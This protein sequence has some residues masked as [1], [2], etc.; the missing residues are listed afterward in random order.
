MAV[1]AVAVVAA[2]PF[3]LLPGVASAAPLPATYTATA[4]GDV[5]TVESTLAGGELAAVDL[6]HSDA[7]VDS[8]AD[9]AA[10]A[11]SANLGAQVG[12]F[13]T[14]D[15]DSN[16]TT[17]PPSGSD[18]GSLLEASA[19]GLNTGVITY[20]DTATW[21]GAEACVDDGTPISQAS[22]ETAGASL[23]LL[24]TSVLTTGVSS[25]TGTTS[26]EQTDPTFDTRAVVATTTGELTDPAL[27]D[28]LLTIDVLSAPTLTATATGTADGSDVV[29]TPAEAT[30]TVGGTT[31]T[32]DAGADV[33][34]D[35]PGVGSV[36]LHL[37]SA[38]ELANRSVAADGT[39][40]SGDAV[41]LTAD[42]TL[43]GGTGT[44]SVDLLPLHAEATAP[45]G[46]VE[47]GRLAPA[48]DIVTP[49]DGSSTDDPTPPI[50]GTSNQPNSTVT[51]VIDGGDPVEVDTDGD[52]NFTY[53]P[54]ASVTDGAGDTATDS[55]TFTVVAADV[56]PTVDITSPEDGSSTDDPTPPI[57]GTSN[58][59]NS[60]VTLVIDGGDPVEVDTDGDGNFT[61]TPTAENDAG[62]ASDSVT[63]TVV[64]ADEEPTVEI[65]DPED[66]SSTDD[67]TPPV[68]GTSNQPNSTVTV[69]IDGGDPVE[70]DT[71]GDGNF[72]YTPTTALACGE[73]TVTVTAE[74]DA[75]TASDSSTFTVLC[76]AGAVADAG[77]ASLAYTGS[78]LGMELSVAA[79]LLAAGVL[80]VGA[81][82]LRRRRFVPRHAAR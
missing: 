43:L 13:A 27:L 19:L 60:T 14:V 45:V 76:A 30:A 55:T 4:S 33:P 11:T 59:P 81:S 38:S 63:F 68:T 46:G 37:N 32:L 69:V 22:T 73:H 15:V 49:A 74:N 5:L 80:F 67:P 2:A 57:T 44:V 82:Q 51:L 65:T 3:V 8:E 66:G 7:S 50:T 39:S 23:D 21:A 16:T 47:C 64:A 10:S 53:T 48:V 17:A 42:I 61:Y 35:V 26:L 24:G 41:A 20:T 28:G 9:P 75:G 1:G 71:D 78:D 34:L 70:V 6:V 56:E 40:A 77:P 52:G 72:T 79:A 36:V 25:V 18:S 29:F 31:V 58:Q 54:E 62:S 12:G